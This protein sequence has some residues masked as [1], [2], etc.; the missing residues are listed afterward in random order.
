MEPL[1]PKDMNTLLRIGIVNS[2]ELWNEYLLEDGNILKVKVTLIKVR[3]HPTDVDDEGN[4]RYA[5][6]SQLLMDVES[7][8]PKPEIGP[9]TI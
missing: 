5:V 6:K 7:A 3:K 2:H 4:P 9:P 1:S 8:Q